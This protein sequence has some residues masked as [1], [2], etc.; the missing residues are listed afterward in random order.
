[1]SDKER[2][3]LRHRMP[4]ENSK[5]YIPKEVFLTAVHF[6]KQYPLWLA[7]LSTYPN[8]NKGVSYD[9]DVVQTSNLSD[10][11]AEMA[12]R[13]AEMARKKNLVD[14]TAEEVGGKKYGRWIVQGVCFDFPFF[15]L[16]DRGIPCGKDLYYQ[17]R[18]RFYY[19]LSKKI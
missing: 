8:A 1:M 9:R 3:A 16:A 19:E 6:C 10:T 15:T 11:T 5:Y 2:D 17:M 13:R 14:S 12:T 4:T 18:R 7:E